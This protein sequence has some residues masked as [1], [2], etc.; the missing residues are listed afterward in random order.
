MYKVR[1]VRLFPRAKSYPP[2]RRIGSYLGIKKTVG[3]W[4]WPGSRTK[5][6]TIRTKL[7]IDY[8]FKNHN[9]EQT[10]AVRLE[11]FN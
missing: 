11:Q 2:Q 9:I 6:S 3:N 5:F 1:I 4:F 7:L 8:R 10:L